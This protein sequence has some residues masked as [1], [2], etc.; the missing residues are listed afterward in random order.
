MNDET[1]AEIDSILCG[2]ELCSVCYHYAIKNGDCRVCNPI[3]LKQLR[4]RE[5]G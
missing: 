1:I 2:G 5:R 4:D 3:E